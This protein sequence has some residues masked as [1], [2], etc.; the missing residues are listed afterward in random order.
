MQREYWSFGHVYSLALFTDAAM[1]APTTGLGT[2]DTHRKS[3]TKPK[4]SGKQR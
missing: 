3:T 4:D 1:A 2:H